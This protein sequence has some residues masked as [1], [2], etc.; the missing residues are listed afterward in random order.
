MATTVLLRI[1]RGVP[2]P[3]FQHRILS[4]LYVPAHPYPQVL[5]G[6]V[7][8]DA[9]VVAQVFFLLTAPAHQIN[10]HLLTDG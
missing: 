5:V 2:E 6:I 8:P 7:G 4:V 9:H 1:L 10:D 3:Y